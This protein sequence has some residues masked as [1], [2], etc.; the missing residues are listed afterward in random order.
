MTCDK[1]EIERLRNVLRAI[2]RADWPDGGTIA[3]ETIVQRLRSMAAEG[4]DADVLVAPPCEI[5][6]LLK[7]ARDFT[8]S[9]T[10]GNID[11]GTDRDARALMARIDAMLASPVPFDTGPLAFTAAEAKETIA[12][13][14]AHENEAYRQLGMRNVRV[15]ELENE[16]KALRAEVRRAKGRK[17]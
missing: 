15:A 11:S 13:C 3:Y 14:R 10:E 17:P 4:I 1:H 12:K 8:D 6:E 2:Y 7:D 9:I 16:V 5:R